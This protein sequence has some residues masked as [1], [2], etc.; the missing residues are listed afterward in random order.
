MTKIFLIA[1]IFFKIIFKTKWR[2]KKPRKTDILIYDN[3]S[4][5]ILNFYLK[6]KRYETF[7]CR[8][9]EINIYII[10]ISILKNGIQNLR[11]NYKINYFKTVSPKV[12]IT[13][14]DENPGFYKLK[15]I[16]P[17]AK[18]VS[19]Q[20][21]FKDNKFYEFISNFKKKNKDYKFKSD[22]CFVL[23]DNDKNKYKKYLES[24]FIS[25]GSIRNNNFPIQEN[26]KKKIKKI[27]FISGVSLKNKE[28]DKKLR[29]IK[30]F[31]ILKKYCEKNK[32]K[33]SFLSKQSKNFLPIHSKYYGGG[34][35][36][37]IPKSN[38]I[39]KTYKLINNSQFVIFEHSTLGFEAISKKIRGVC[40]PDVFPY[41][42][43]SKKYKKKDGLFWSTKINEKDIFSK[44]D[45]VIDL[46][47]NKWN[48]MI[49]KELKDIIIYNPK[50]N[51]FIKKIDSFIY[52]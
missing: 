4:I 19:V 15:N 13:L 35:W 27:L 16:Y 32:I 28:S 31:N 22:L 10:L 49:Q 7:Y 25:L 23:G 29:Q 40:F 2:F 37:Y 38:D 47:F 34:N 50:N 36:E 52:R 51:I 11:E 21:A 26:Y 18:Y 1:K 8:Y 44:I 9:E 24:K 39:K 17:I 3:E 43:Y 48:K 33:L 5:E 41:K 45:K 14:I 12:V 20:I 30:I 42:F 6:K 46:N